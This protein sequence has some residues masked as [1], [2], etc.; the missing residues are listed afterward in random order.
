MTDASVLYAMANAFKMGGIKSSYNF[1]G[2]YSH[3]LFDYLGGTIT[4]TNEKI[5]YELAWGS[6]QAG[7][8]AL[9]TFKNVG[10]NDAADPF[11]NSMLTGVGGGL[12]LVV[13]DDIELQGSQCI[14]DSR[15]YFSFFGGLWLEPYDFDSAILF[16]KVAPQLSR[17]FNLPVVIR[18]TNKTLRFE[19]NHGRAVLGASHVLELAERIVAGRFVGQPTEPLVHPINGNVH[20]KLISSKNEAVQQFVDQ[21][22]VLLNLNGLQNTVYCGYDG[23]GDKNYI[24]T[25]PVPILDTMHITDIYEVGDPVIVTQLRLQTSEAQITSHTTGYEV[26]NADNYIVTE[27][28][29]RLFRL[30][31]PHYDFITGDL[32]E[33]TKDSLDTL[34]HCLCFGSAIS[35]ATG[36]NEAGKKALAITGDASFYHS[37]KNV[38]NEASKRGIILKVVLID[39]GG[40]YGTGGQKIPGVMVSDINLIEIDF[41]S[42]N[43]KELEKIVASFVTNRKSTILK[44]NHEV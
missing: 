4:S 14:L 33:Y 20:R 39:N 37:A 8:P 34:T 13:F 36:M 22:H 18:L 2:F 25:L 19:E 1:P 27:R 21:L 30:L 28:Y 40:S 12:V 31:K 16:A 10:L 6:S 43:D 32:G 9:V 11:I 41:D 24:V 44:V 3:K 15:H 26:K 29:E 7:V 38:I 35:V 23:P 5:A 17:M 42:I